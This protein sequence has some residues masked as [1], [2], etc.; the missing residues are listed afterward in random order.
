M[1]LKNKIHYL[2]FTLIYFA[3]LTHLYSQESS[4]ITGNDE[5]ILHFKTWNQAFEVPLSIFKTPLIE[6]SK[7]EEIL[8]DPDGCT[9]NTKINP[10]RINISS[11]DFEII[12]NFLK[13]GT[14]SFGYAAQKENIEFSAAE[15]KLKSLVRYK[16][17][18]Q[19]P[20]NKILL[21][22]KAIELLKENEI[23]QFKVLLM[24]E[25]FSGINS[26]QIE[27]DQLVLFFEKMNGLAGKFDRSWLKEINSKISLLLLSEYELSLR[28]KIEYQFNFLPFPV[29]VNG[30]QDEFNRYP[31]LE[32]ELKFVEAG[33]NFKNIQVWEKVLFEGEKYLIVIELKSPQTFSSLFTDQLVRRNQILLKNK[34]RLIRNFNEIKHFFSLNTPIPVKKINEAIYFVS[35]KLE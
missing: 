24:R 12:L 18:F 31:H 4:E 34:F 22:K 10:F 1:K 28:S 17:T 33:S 29:Y 35:D 7:F 15:L 19:F 11:S 3:G 25:D 5:M 23:S 27:K 32:T 21:I 26:A 8:S 16:T 14:Y 2:I 6:G 13:N 30:G 20:N 9:F